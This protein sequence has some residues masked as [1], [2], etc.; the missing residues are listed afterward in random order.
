MCRYTPYLFILCLLPLSLF[1]TAPTKPNK[2]YPHL[3]S[4]SIQFGGVSNTG[5]SDNTNINGKGSLKHTYGP[6]LN[7]ASIEGQLNNA[8]GERTAQNLT[9][10]ASSKFLFSPRDYLFGSFNTTYDAFGTYDFFI[11]EAVGYGRILIDNDTQRLTL[12]GGPGG[13]HQRISG[14]RVFQN[15][16]IAYFSGVYEHRLSETAEFKQTFN[17]DYSNLNTHTEAVTAIKTKVIRNIALE[18]SFTVMND[19]V[20]P[21]NSKNTRKTDTITKVAVVYEF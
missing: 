6:W 16:V 9:G 19:T 2:T 4:G 17:T 3:W 10:R 8:N 1:A 20:I 18:L 11:K 5:N 13:T 12:E 7:E 14:T 21:P 15:A